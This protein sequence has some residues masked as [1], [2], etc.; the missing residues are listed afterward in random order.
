[1]ITLVFFC[2]YSKALLEVA[3]KHHWHMDNLYSAIFGLATF[4]AGFLFAIYTY[5][6]ND[7]KQDFGR[8]TAIDLLLASVEIYDIRNGDGDSSI[9][10]NNSILRYCS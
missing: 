10:N 5:V 2:A 3:D 8:D 9:N 7:R 6:K 4:I 1:M